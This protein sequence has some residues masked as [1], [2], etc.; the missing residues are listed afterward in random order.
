M[1]FAK[2]NAKINKSSNFQASR[3]G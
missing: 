2:K 3:W 1:P